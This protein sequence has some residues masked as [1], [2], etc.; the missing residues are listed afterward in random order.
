MLKT[1]KEDLSEVGIAAAVAEGEEDHGKA[2]MVEVK[3]TCRMILVEDSGA[4]LNF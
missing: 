1:N 2:V 3:E 4:R